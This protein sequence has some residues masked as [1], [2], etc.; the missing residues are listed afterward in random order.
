MGAGDG[1]LLLPAI[2]KG[3]QGQQQDMSSVVP[4]PCTQKEMRNQTSLLFLLFVQ[5]SPEEP[6]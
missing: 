2:G 6:F 3:V 5:C 4:W 1:L